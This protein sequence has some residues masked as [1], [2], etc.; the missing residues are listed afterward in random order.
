[1][2]A[3]GLSRWRS[4]GRRSAPVRPAAEL[5]EGAMSQPTNLLRDVEDSIKDWYSYYLILNATVTFI[6][7][8]IIALPATIASNM[9]PSLNQGLGLIAAVLGGILTSL[10]LTSASA[11]FLTARNLLQIAKYHYDQ[12][13]DEGKLLDS[14]AKAKALASFLP[15]PNLV[16]SK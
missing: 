1:S 2:P 7:I 13:N 9:W 6:G 10:N 15:Q 11:N 12:D 14:Y 5:W 4:S 16:A 3:A 8:M